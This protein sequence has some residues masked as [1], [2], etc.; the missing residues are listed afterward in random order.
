MLRGEL[1]PP[2]CV[3]LAFRGDDGDGVVGDVVG[4]GVVGDVDDAAADAVL[5]AALDV[6]LDALVVKKFGGA[7]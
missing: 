1:A 3:A 5:A 6:A 7:S 4:D 2:L